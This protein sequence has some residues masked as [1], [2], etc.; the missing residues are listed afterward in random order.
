VRKL[1]CYYYDTKHA[2]VLNCNYVTPFCSDQFGVFFF[3][4]WPSSSVHIRYIISIRFEQ[5]KNYNTQLYYNRVK[6]N[7]KLEAFSWFVVI[8]Y[9]EFVTK[10]TNEKFLNIFIYLCLLNDVKIVID[11]L[12]TTVNFDW[13][14]LSYNWWFLTDDF[15]IIWKYFSLSIFFFCINLN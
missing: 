10:L 3:F 13:R 5:F 8:R 15:T 14:S 4:I 11:L 6:Y 2:R 9:Y 1:N 7:S 12:Y